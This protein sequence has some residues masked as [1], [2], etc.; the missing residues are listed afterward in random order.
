[1][2]A[3]GD[4]V[5]A[6]GFDVV[7]GENQTVRRA[8]LNRRDSLAEDDRGLRIMRRHLYDAEVIAYHEVGVEPPAEILVERLRAVDVRNAEQHD[9][10]LHVNGF[11]LCDF[12][13]FHNSSDEFPAIVEKYDLHLSY[14]SI[15]QPAILS[16][17]L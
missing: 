4:K 1:L 9:F 11:S 12:C 2:D 8:G 16:P 15:Y 13:C 5:V 17:P 3:A 7:H 10:E 6:G 14:P